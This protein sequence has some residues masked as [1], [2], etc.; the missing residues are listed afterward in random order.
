MKAATRG[1]EEPATSAESSSGVQ[2]DSRPRLTCTDLFCGAGALAL[3]F[4]QAGFETVLAVDNEPSAVQT[5][6]EN[7]G[8]RAV[9]ADL[10]T[11]LELPPT[12]IIIGGPPCQG[13]SSAGLRRWGDARNTLIGW[14]A[15][16][17]AQLQPRAFLFENVEGFLTG[18]DG[19]WLIDLLEPLVEA[20]YRIH[21]RKVNAANYGVPQHRKRVIAVGGL[22]FDPTFPLPTHT[23]RGAPGAHLA[24]RHLPPGPTLAEA[25]TGLP[26]AS[27]VLPGYPDDHYYR[28]LAGVDLQRCHGL[29][30]GQTMRDLPE[31][32]WHDS[33]RRRAHRRVMDGTP[34][35]RRGGAPAALRRLHADQPS[36]AVTSAAV[37]EFIHPHEDR[38]LT[39]R[40]AA[41]LQTFPD[42]FHFLGSFS[43]RAQLIGNA[44]PPRLAEVFARQ[45]S[46]DLSE[47]SRVAER[48][49]LISFVPTL[50]QG[51]S[52]ALA[53]TASVVASM[54]QRPAGRVDQ[55]ALCL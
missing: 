12:D 41:R 39:L 32:L 52:P 35:E 10:T 42:D 17:V 8:P 33:Y 4:H 46:R 44:V 23:A 18:E 1:T 50:S 11:P 54:F 21:L 29:G 5:F 9:L 34:T 13:F 16:T 24:G 38:L 36:K 22:G 15:Q 49:A 3:G 45:L 53:Y 6:N 25:L 27:P 20:G 55:T 37:R 43:E 48:G 26:P 30:Q 14:F 2:R 19:R 31:D 40:E 47:P 7:L 28:P 51:M